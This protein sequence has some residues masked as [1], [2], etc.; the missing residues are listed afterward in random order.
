MQYT[1]KDS[2]MTKG[3]AILAMLCLHLFCREGSDVLGNPLLWLTETVPA[4]FWIGFFSEYCVDL[5]AICAGYGYYLL[6]KQGRNNISS[7]RKRVLRLMT[8]YWIVLCLVSL[9][10]LICFPKGNIP[11][12]FSLFLQN[13][14]LYRSYCGAW[15]F[16]RS[17][18]FMLLLPSAIVLWLSKRL[19]DRL[20]LV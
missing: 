9:I 3:I 13:A 5:Y 7:R 15:W 19:N 6:Y 2:I 4:V 1:R 8:T 16:L 18:V 11:G 14:V 10:G 20:G 17:Y 12:S